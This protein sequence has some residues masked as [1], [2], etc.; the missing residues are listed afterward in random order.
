MPRTAAAGVLAALATLTC[1]AA[2]PVAGDG[3]PRHA[4]DAPPALPRRTEDAPPSLPRRAQDV[5][6]ALLFNRVPLPSSP[7]GPVCNDGSTPSIMYRNCSA[8]WDRKPGGPDYCLVDVVRWMVIFSGR[9]W[10]ED[11]WGGLGRDGGGG[12][13]AAAPPPPSPPSGPFCY[14]AASCAARAPTLT[15]S[16]G[17]PDTAFPGGLVI[18]FAEVNPNLYKSHAAV[19][20]YC[21]SDLWAGNGSAALDGKTWHFHGAAM[22]DAVIDALFAVGGGGAGGLAGAD[23]VLIAGPPGIIARIAHLAARI[24]AGKRRALGNATAVVAVSALADG[25]AVLLPSLPPLSPPPPAQC[26]TDADCPPH[27][28]LPAAAPLWQ[29]P[30]AALQAW[31]P[32]PAVTAWR[33]WTAPRLLAPAPG[34]GPV[35]GNVSLLV[36]APQFDAVGLAAYGAWPAANASGS[37]ARAWAETVYAPAVRAAV[38]ALVPGGGGSAP[39]GGAGAEGRVVAAADAASAPAPSALF[40]TGCAGPSQMSMSTAFYRTLA[41]CV[42]AAGRAH[43]DSFGQA[44]PAFVIPDGT[45]HV[46][47]L[48]CEDA[49]ASWV[50]GNACEPV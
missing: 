8:N 13:A 34:G 37:A 45:G 27:L 39:A 26:T 50:C 3:G 25:G 2:P 20:P 46:E 14:S 15:S 17:L 32:E 16:A 4:Q 10:R 29:P 36:H 38:A 23:E 28:A 42:D 12:G 19:A 33:C 31:C 9:D 44:V 49:C 1:L 7:G 30:L 35:G 43:N 21:S 40:S 22:A 18:P 41:Q 47:P 5:P 24:L 6:P 48:S 11:L